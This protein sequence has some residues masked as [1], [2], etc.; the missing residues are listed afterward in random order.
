MGERED[1]STTDGLV[2]GGERS[3]HTIDGYV[4]RRD[5]PPP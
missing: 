1:I 5:L 4:D 3:G 2:A